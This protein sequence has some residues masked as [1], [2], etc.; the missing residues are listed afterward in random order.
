MEQSRKGVA[1][2]P[3][4]RCSSYWKGSLLVALD[5][6]H[7]LTVIWNQVFIS[8]LNN[9]QADLIHPSIEPTQTGP[10][11]NGDEEGVPHS[12]DIQNCSLLIRCNLAS[13]PEHPVVGTFCPLCKGVLSERHQLKKILFRCDFLI[14]AL[15]FTPL[16]C[17]YFFCH[18]FLPLSRIALAKTEDWAQ[19]TMMQRERENGRGWIRTLRRI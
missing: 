1:P 13:Y 16:F 19:L 7:Q 11:R 5:Y 4:P 6:C 3:S 15:Q 14:S 10:M 12:L 2:S 8:N 17:L 9:F 18:S